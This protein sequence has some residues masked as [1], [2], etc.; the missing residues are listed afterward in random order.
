M[1]GIA[2]IA[3]IT[4]LRVPPAIEQTRLA[5]V[6]DPDTFEVTRSVLD[7]GA[8]S[9]TWV[10][11]RDGRAFVGDELHDTR[12]AALHAALDGAKRRLQRDWSA[13]EALRDELARLTE[14]YPQVPR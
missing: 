10:D 12:P 4:S 14:G 8:G 9:R 5:W 13:V 7:L 1:D 11:R 6:V 3:A 2:T